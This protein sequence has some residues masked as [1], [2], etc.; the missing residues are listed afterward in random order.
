[1]ALFI[2]RR[3]VGA[4]ALAD[5]GKE[6]CELVSVHLL[7]LFAG[8]LGGLH[9]VQVHINILSLQGRTVVLRLSQGNLPEGLV[10]QHLLQGRQV[11]RQLLVHTA[12]DGVQHRFHFRVKHHLH[13]Q[14]AAHVGHF[15]RLLQQG[16]GQLP[17]RTGRAQGRLAAAGVGHTDISGNAL[18]G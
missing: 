11:Q 13:I 6:V 2:G 7:D 17:G 4:L 14:A 10:V 8:G 9:A 1:M 12:E 18:F 15:L 5:I 16:R 3:L